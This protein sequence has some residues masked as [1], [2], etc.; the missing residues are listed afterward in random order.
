LAVGLAFQGTLGNFAAGAMLLIFRPFK[1]GDVIRA[2]GEIG[3][4]TEIELFTTELTT[5]DNRRIIVPNGKIFGDT[6]E[7]ISHHETRRIEVS[8][9]TD[10]AA[11]TRRTRD[12][13]LEATGKVTTL[14]SD[15]APVAVL[16]ELGDSAVSWKVRAWCKS[17]DYWGA[18][19]ALT[20]EVKLSLDAAKIG[21]PYPQLDV[22]LDK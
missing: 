12:I 10:Y 5:A 18:L 13:L 11:D 7:N 9:G 17:D 21:I 20:E 15:P 19:E 14:L 16:A 8:V 3:K 22:H 4:V 2:G 1:V 6:I